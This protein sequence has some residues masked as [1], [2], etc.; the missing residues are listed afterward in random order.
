MPGYRYYQ[1]R[2]IINDDVAANRGDIDKY[3]KAFERALV[4]AGYAPSKRNS[5]ITP[6]SSE[7]AVSNGKTPDLAI[8][9]P[10]KIEP[11]PVS[12][13]WLEKLLTALANFIVKGWRK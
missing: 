5:D 9:S 3:A 8:T 13:N 10:A 2:A 6:K 7:I 4:A 12:G 1:S 11:G